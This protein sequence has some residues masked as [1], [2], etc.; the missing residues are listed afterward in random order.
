M[1]QVLKQQE[2]TWPF[3]QPRTKNRK[4]SLSTLHQAMAGSSSIHKTMTSST[5]SSS[6]SSSSTTTAKATSGQS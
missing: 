5:Y 1:H 4:D 2:S 3:D 6:S